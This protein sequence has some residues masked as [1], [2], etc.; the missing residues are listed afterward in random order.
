VP[1]WGEL[2][3]FCSDKIWTSDLIE[4]QGRIEM[5]EI[6]DAEKSCAGRIAKPEQTFISGGK[7]GQ[8]YYEK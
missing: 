4:R 2:T 8:C 3:N 1:H 7:Y 6:Q 5:K